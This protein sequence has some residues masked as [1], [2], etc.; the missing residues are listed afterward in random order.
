[1]NKNKYGLTDDEL[2][3]IGFE[4]EKYNIVDFAGEMIAELVMKEY[5]NTDPHNDERRFYL[6]LY[7]DAG[8]DESL[9]KINIKAK[10]KV[11]ASKK[12]TLNFTPKES[13]DVNFG[14][15]ELNT[16]WHL[17]F[18]K[19]KHYYIITKAIRLE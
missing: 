1:M 4:K 3:A 10:R 14:K 15:V 17:W 13:S 9:Y 11:F 8:T 2:I 19:K 7:L 12:A 5:N 6:T 18:K 16:I